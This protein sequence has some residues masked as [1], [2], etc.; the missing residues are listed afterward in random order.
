MPLEEDTI[1]QIWLKAFPQAGSEKIGE[2]ALEVAL[3]DAV[4]PSDA[5]WLALPTDE[6]QGRKYAEVYLVV[7]RGLWRFR[8]SSERRP[9]GQPSQCGGDYFAIGDNAGF[10]LKVIYGAAGEPSV[11][12]TEMEWSFS[13]LPENFDLP[14]IK[15]SSQDDARGHDPERRAFVEALVAVIVRR[16]AG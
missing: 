9:D 12:V 10:S 11:P 2:R 4:V 3:A 14:R 6:D 5:P 13:G 16:G 15:T 1:K 7:G 8:A